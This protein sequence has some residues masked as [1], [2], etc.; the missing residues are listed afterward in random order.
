M[1]LDIVALVLIWVFLYFT[2]FPFI[3][4]I[5]FTSGYIAITLLL[6]YRVIIKALIDKRNKDYVTEI[7]KFVKFKEEYSFNGD[8]TGQIKMHFLYP[9]SFISKV[10]IKV[11]ND[12]GEEKKLRSVISLKQ[13]IEL[14][15]LE[16]HQIEYFKVTY[17][18]NSKIIINIDLVDDINKIASKKKQK[19]IQKALHCINSSVE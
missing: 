15:I 6:N 11:I 18:R 8:N 7:I 9:N 3:A 10:K 17:L 5:I 1:I 19:I 4:Y 13:S 2:E 12:H 14:S 16:D